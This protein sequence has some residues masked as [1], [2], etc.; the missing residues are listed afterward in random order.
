[1]RGDA[2]KTYSPGVFNKMTGDLVIPRL[3]MSAEAVM[4]GENESRS[5]S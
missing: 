3:K 2:E 1:M 4:G 5:Q